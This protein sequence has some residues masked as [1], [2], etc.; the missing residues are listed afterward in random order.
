MTR[1]V[2]IAGMWVDD[3]TADDEYAY[4]DAWADDVGV[5]P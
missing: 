5:L 4:A 3:G 1:V 2:V